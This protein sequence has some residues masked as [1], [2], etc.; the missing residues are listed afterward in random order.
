MADAELVGSMLDVLYGKQSDAN[1]VEDISMQ[2][3]GQAEATPPNQ[4]GSRASLG[5]D[6]LDAVLD[7]IQA[8]IQSVT[9]DFDLKK[10]KEV[11][12]MLKSCKD[13]MRDTESALCV[14]RTGLLASHYLC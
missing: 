8:T 5:R 7:A 9:D 6:Q 14:I 11:D 13:P 3:D 4:S 10:V 2:V 12:R 1:G